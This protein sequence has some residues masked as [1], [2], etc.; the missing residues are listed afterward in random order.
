MFIRYVGL[1]TS[2]VWM[3]KEFRWTLHSFILHVFSWGKKTT[4]ADFS[5]F[6]LVWI[7]NSIDDKY[8]RFYNKK[9]Q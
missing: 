5:L 6:L 2:D 7:F 4:F 9:V 1:Y 3:L 8:F